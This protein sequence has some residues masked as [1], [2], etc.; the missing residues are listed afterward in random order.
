MLIDVELKLVGLQF[1]PAMSL[2]H[3]LLVLCEFS[4]LVIQKFFRIQCR[5]TAK[6]RRGNRQT[7]DLTATSPAA[8]T[9]GTLVAVALPAKL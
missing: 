2:H 3:F 6:P 8:N 7:V 4:R 1:V 9:P 5:H